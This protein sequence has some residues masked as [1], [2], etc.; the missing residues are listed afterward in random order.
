M[1]KTLHS[2]FLYH[3]FLCCNEEYEKMAGSISDRVVSRIE[4]IYQIVKSTI[5]ER[6]VIEGDWSA[7]TREFCEF[8]K[9]METQYDQ[10]RNPQYCMYGFYKHIAEIE[11][12]L[13][14]PANQRTTRIKSDLDII[15]NFHKFC[16]A[17]Y[18]NNADAII[19]RRLKEMFENLRDGKKLKPIHEDIFDFLLKDFFP[20]Y[21][22]LQGGLLEIINSKLWKE[23][24]FGDLTHQ[25]FIMDALKNDPRYERVHELFNKLQ[26]MMPDDI[27]DITETFVRISTL[28]DGIYDDMYNCKIPDNTGN[29]PIEY[30]PIEEHNISC[31]HS[32]ILAFMRWIPVI[33][34]DKLDEKIMI[35]VDNVI[36]KIKVR[37]YEIINN[38]DD[39]KERLN[40]YP[41]NDHDT[42]FVQ[43]GETGLRSLLIE[44]MY[45]EQE[46]VSCFRCLYKP[47]TSIVG[48]G[49]KINE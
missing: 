8:V 7:L 18:G 36:D 41:I 4:E 42:I 2:P 12:Y 15:E 1:R 35:S 3:L 5:V 13:M 48:K 6:E 31:L 20:Q 37:I 46:I 25:K 23:V 38:S 26:D 19:P 21:S 45:N 14:S 22:N 10:V 27:T 44:A 29:S 43:G 34:Q 9:K 16:H 17:Y 24:A 39:L 47:E 28:L 30:D 40:T 49:G 11:Q 32:H 33:P